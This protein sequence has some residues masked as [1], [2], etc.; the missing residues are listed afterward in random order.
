MNFNEY[1]NK[2]AEFAVY[3]VA[4]LNACKPDQKVAA[5]VYPALGLA[6]ET[7]EVCDKLKKVIRDKNGAISD[8]TKVE[9]KK[10]LG[11]VLWYLAAISNELGIA[12]DD[13]AESNIV[14]LTSRKTR[15]MINGEGDNR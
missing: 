4:Y 3:P 12:F 5:W 8:E 6:G 11:D 7:G 14:K 13:V 2:A 9:I 1:Q 15:G 10:E